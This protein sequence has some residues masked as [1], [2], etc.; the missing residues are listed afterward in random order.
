MKLPT[1]IATILILFKYEMSW[2][3]RLAHIIG[4]VSEFSDV[5]CKIEDQTNVYHCNRCSRCLFP[6]N[7][8]ILMPKQQ[9]LMPLASSSEDVTD[10]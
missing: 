7:E 9:F 8:H 3:H 4:W 6:R 10:P 1:F 2:W 5:Y